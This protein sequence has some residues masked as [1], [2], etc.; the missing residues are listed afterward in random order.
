MCVLITDHKKIITEEK[1]NTE[2]TQQKKLGKKPLE[3][4]Q[5][6]HWEY[7]YPPRHQSGHGCCQHHH[8]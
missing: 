3:S 7:Q 8:Q 1:I 2:L 5:Q 4:L 6:P